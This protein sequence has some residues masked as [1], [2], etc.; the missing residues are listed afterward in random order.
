[1]NGEVVGRVIII[2]GEA[3]RHLRDRWG[4]LK[5]WGL[6]FFKKYGI[7]EIL[8]KFKKERR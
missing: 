8:N 7:M 3:Q 5:N 2:E 1:M 6:T 4:K